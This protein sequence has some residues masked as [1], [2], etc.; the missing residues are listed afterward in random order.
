MKLRPPF[1][2][3]RYNALAN[4]CW[5]ALYA[6]FNGLQVFWTHDTVYFFMDFT[7]AKTP[8]VALGLTLLMVAVFAGTCALSRLKWRLVLG[9]YGHPADPHRA[10]AAICS[11]SDVE[12]EEPM[13]AMAATMDPEEADGG[14]G[15][16]GGGGGINSAAPYTLMPAGALENKR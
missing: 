14:G 4:A 5:G 6:L 12:P 15:G 7:L 9:R 11:C 1:S 16:G 10:D 3:L 2:L 13:L 8:F